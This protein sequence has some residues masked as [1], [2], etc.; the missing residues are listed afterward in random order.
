MDSHHAT[1]VL[2]L[3]RTLLRTA[4]KHSVEITNSCFSVPHKG[5]K[6]EVSV[7]I[8]FAESMY[9][10][11]SPEELILCWY[12]TGHDII[13]YP[14][15]IQGYYGRKVPVPIHLTVDRSLQNGH[16]STKAYVSTLIGVPG[17]TMG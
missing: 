7:D 6:D 8:K 10:L 17:S 14:V 12:P 15:L 3:I 9:E 13:E 4:D 11:K 2:P 16:M 1:R 5:S